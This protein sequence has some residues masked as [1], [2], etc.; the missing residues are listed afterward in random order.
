MAWFSF[1]DMRFNGW[2]R[3]ICKADQYGRTVRLDS[4]GGGYRTNHHRQSINRW[5]YGGRRSHET[6]GAGQGSKEDGDG[7]TVHDD[8]GAGIIFVSSLSVLGICV[9]ACDGR[10]DA[11][12]SF[13]R[14]VGSRLF[15]G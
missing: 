3:V 5:T 13:Q 9:P 12:T 14:F 8:V 7:E 10:R 4:C 6:L 1:A 2:T 15:D 11:N